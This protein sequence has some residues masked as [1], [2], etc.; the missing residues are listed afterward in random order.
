MICLRCA[1]AS[2]FKEYYSVYLLLLNEQLQS[3]SMRSQVL[4]EKPLRDGRE[5]GGHNIG[6]WGSRGGDGDGRKKHRVFCVFLLPFFFISAVTSY[7]LMARSLLYFTAE[8]K[9]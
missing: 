7:S 8:T 3:E 9:L 5:R 4:P 1:G 6:W 2:D